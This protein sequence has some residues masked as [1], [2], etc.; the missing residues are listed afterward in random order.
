MTI[1]AEVEAEIARLFAVEHWKVGT[2]ADQLGVHHDVVRRVLGLL[3]EGPRRERPPLLVAP[4][5][6]FVKETLERYPR[7]CSTRLLDMLRERGFRGSERTL[8][9]F[10][11]MVRPTSNREAFLRLD[12]L[13][14]E[15]AQIDW[16]HVGPIA[17]PGGSRSL[18]LFVMVLSW[19]RA[20]WGEFCFD[21]SVHSLLRSLSRAAA[22]FGGTTRQWL[23]DNPKIVVLERRGEAVRFHPLLLDLATAFH[24]QPRLCRPRRGN[25]K[26]RVERKIRFLRDRFLAGREILSIEQGNRELLAF[27]EKIAH[28]MPHPDFGKKSI[29]DCL[30][31]EKE[32][33]LRVPDPLPATDLVMPVAIDKTAFAHFDTNLYSVPPD[34]VQQTLTLVADDR[35]VRILRGQTVVAE[36]GRSFG[37][38]QKVEAPGHRAEIIQRKRGADSSTGRDRLRAAAPDIDILVG[39]WVEAG[40]NVGLMVAQTRRL[41]DLY[42]QDIFVKAVAETIAR[43]THDPGALGVLCEKHRRAA[44]HPVP[45]EVPMADTVPDRDV[46]PHDLGGYDD[47]D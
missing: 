11:A 14:G 42:G 35:R 32:R 25:E 3:P 8:R 19:S 23:F 12:P 22:Y 41:L 30:A 40:R 21:L 37:Q 33:L 13:I 16:A 45:I 26:G 38:R 1:A 31:E 5:E 20:M 7:L 39:R 10:V 44:E 34:V 46:V 4:Y 43:G 17:V 29:A 28:T 27:V 2:I 6:G 36:H 18:W 24:V 47:V 9:R 15:Q